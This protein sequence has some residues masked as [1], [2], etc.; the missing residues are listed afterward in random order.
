MFHLTLSASHSQSIQVPV[1]AC[2]ED[3]TKSLHTV[4]NSAVLGSEEVMLGISKRQKES[5]G[6]LT[7]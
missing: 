4:L 5:K 7:F 2:E 1:S 3:F 6:I